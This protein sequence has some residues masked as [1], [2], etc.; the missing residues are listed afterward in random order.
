MIGR[1]L[2]VTLCSSVAVAT[3]TAIAAAQTQIP[4]SVEFSVPKPPTVALS[5]S[6]AFLSY[7]LHVTNLTP[8]AMYL[9]RV[10]V[11][12]ANSHASVFTLAD[13]ALI[14]ALNRVAPPTCRAADSNQSPGRRVSSGV[15]ARADSRGGPRVRLS[16]D[17]RRRETIRRPS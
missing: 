17:P 12:D 15:G 3:L 13:S 14:R 7:E 1:R 10:E 11:F 16:L 6:G 2:G 9:R 5:D 8:S 4:P